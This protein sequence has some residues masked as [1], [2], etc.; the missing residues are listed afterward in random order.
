M[1]Q[2]EIHQDTYP[3][4]HI[5]KGVQQKRNYIASEDYIVNLENSIPMFMCSNKL[6][7]KNKVGKMFENI[8]KVAKNNERNL[9]FEQ[10]NFLIYPFDKIQIQF[11]KNI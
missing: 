11:W 1:Y 5:G 4:F 7:S 8:R 9:S 10:E 3:E 2:R 6:K